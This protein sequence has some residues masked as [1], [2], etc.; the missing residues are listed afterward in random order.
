[1]NER[2]YCIVMLPFCKRVRGRVCDYYREN[3][4]NV[5]GSNIVICKEGIIHRTFYLK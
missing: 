2:N 1:M 3:R 5:G 4:L